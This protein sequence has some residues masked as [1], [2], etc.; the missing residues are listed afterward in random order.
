MTFKTHM[1]ILVL[2]LV[3]LFTSSVLACSTAA[4]NPG[5]SGAVS[6]NNPVNGVPRV[7]GECGFKVTGSGYVQDNSPVDESQFIGRFY[8]LPQLNGTGTANIFVAY[9]DVASSV[10][11]TVR[12]DGTDIILNATPAGGSSVKFPANNDN[13]NL[14]EFSWKSGASGSLW[15]NSDATKDTASRT[16]TS[17]TGAV[18]SVRLGAPNGFGGLT[19]MAFFD[20]YESHRTQAVGP[21]LAGDSN[22]DGVV[23]DDDLVGIVEEFLSDT[24]PGGVTDCNLDAEINSGDVNCAVAIF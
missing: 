21:L 12:Y 9:S 24:Y 20:D 18:N 6:T 16:F 4:W 15:I 5:A 8:F 17:G 22:L 1:S 2:L 23:N 13:W 10:L 11:F 7:A 19:G 3:S 14:I